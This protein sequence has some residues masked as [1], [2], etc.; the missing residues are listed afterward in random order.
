MQKAILFFSDFFLVLMF[1][2]SFLFQN[3][4][5][6][7]IYLRHFVNI[8]KMLCIIYANVIM[9]C[10]KNTVYIIIEASAKVE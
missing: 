10:K 3:L 5:E 1:S 9:Y 7:R 6:N 2:V 4:F 8:L